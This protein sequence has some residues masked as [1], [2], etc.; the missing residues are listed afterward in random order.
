MMGFALAQ[1]ANASKWTNPILIDTVAA[2]GVR[3]EASAF[4]PLENQIAMHSTVAE[5]RGNTKRCYK[6]RPTL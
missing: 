6:S 4:R 1:L 2:R 5:E 3:K